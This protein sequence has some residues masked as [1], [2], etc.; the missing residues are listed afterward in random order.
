M[1]RIGKL[2]VAIPSGV[3]ITVDQ[4]IITVKGPKG[5]LTQPV[6]SDVTVTIEGDS[7]VVNRK[8]DEKVAKSQHGLIRTLI[9]NMVAGVTDG[10]E[11]KLRLSGVGYRV[12]GGGNTLNFSLGF[13]H[14][15]TFTTPEGVEVAVNQ[16]TITVKG[17]SKQLVGQVA[18]DIRA[19]RKPEPYKGK[20]IKYSGEKIIRK[21]G[22]TG[23]K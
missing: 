14:P 16:N 21:A 17:I 23:T 10:F 19:L 13:S 1:S 3:E 2:P 20:G 7:V 6:L 18:A 11:K 4:G 9:A 8:S 12:S 22:K 15:V 5:T